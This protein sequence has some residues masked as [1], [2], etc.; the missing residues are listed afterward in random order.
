MEKQKKVYIVGMDGYLGWALC[1]HLIANGFKVAGCDNGLRRR[2]VSEVGGGSGIPISSM[3][4]RLKEIKKVYGVDVRFDRIDV[5]YYTPIAKAL[6]EFQPDAIVNFGQIPSAPYSMID[7]AHAAF[8]HKNNVIGNLNI[9][10]GMREH[11]PEA[12][13]VKLGTMGEYGTPNIDIEE[14]YFKITHNGRAD[15]VM[16]PRK[17]GSWYHC[18]KV[19]DTI[20]VDFAC[21]MWDLKATDIMQGVVYGT[22]INAFKLNKFLR[23]RFDYDEAFGTAINRFAAQVVAG[24][25]ITPYGKGEQTRGYLPLRDSMKC[26]MLIIQNPPEA[27]EH[28]VFNQLDKTYTVNQLA[29]IV[30][31]QAKRHGYNP[32]IE[33]IPNPRKEDEEHYYN[34]RTDGLRRLGY[35]PLGDIDGEVYCMIQDLKENESRVRKYADAIMPKTRWV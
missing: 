31:D 11:C 6:K 32:V 35:Q 22:R 23:T 24:V 18:T 26:I 12:H 3:K 5:Q 17:P 33:N 14:G 1:C 4:R 7:E 29:E 2:M 8:T 10:N 9:I 28:R 19:H 30:A 34:P 27:G 13:L 15:K 16:F 21:R 20:N 25:P